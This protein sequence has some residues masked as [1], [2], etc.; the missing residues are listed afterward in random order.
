MFSRMRVVG[1]HTGSLNAF[2][3]SS[4]KSMRRLN[5]GTLALDPL[6]SVC[7]GVVGAAI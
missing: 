3:L 6:G 1:R 5:S 2:C 4:D 7:C